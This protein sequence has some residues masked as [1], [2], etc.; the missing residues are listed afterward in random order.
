MKITRSSIKNLRINDVVFG[1]HFITGK[2]T[3]WRVI[4]RTGLDFTL[5]SNLGESWEIDAASMC[6]TFPLFTNSH[7]VVEVS[8]SDTINK[9]ISVEDLL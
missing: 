9:E 1:L 7:E 3:T 4:E 5:K 8:K 2:K 6:S